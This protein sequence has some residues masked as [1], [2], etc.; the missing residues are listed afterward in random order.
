MWTRSYFRCAGRLILNIWKPFSHSLI[1]ECLDILRLALS[2]RLSQ[3]Q[4]KRNTLCTHTVCT[5]Y[6]KNTLWTGTFKNCVLF[7]IRRTSERSLFQFLS[8]LLSPEIFFR[9]LK[10]KKEEK[11]FKTV[12]APGEAPQNFPFSRR[13]IKTLSPQNQL[14][15]VISKLFSNEELLETIYVTEDAPPNSLP[16]YKREA[17]QNGLPP[18]TSS[19]LKKC[20]C[21]SFSKRYSLQN[22]KLLKNGRS[23]SSKRSLLSKKPLLKN[24]SLFIKEK[25]LKTVS[26]LEK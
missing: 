24:G 19:S 8:C 10:K 9:F 1:S 20:I 17:P 11:L 16:S 6:E 22:E 7:L 2:C 25:L 26:P 23:S 14:K 21:R 13:L 5:G 12:S 4:V 18:W 3:G 15:S